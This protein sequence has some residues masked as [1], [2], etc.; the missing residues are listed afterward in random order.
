LPDFYNRLHAAGQART[1]GSAALLIGVAIYGG[2]P[3]LMAK[4][5]VFMG[6]VFLTTTIAAHALGRAAYLSGM[7]YA[8]GTQTHHLASSHTN[9]DKTLS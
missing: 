4:L 3:T 2:T 7:R 8:R 9:S 5:L 6:F 1:L